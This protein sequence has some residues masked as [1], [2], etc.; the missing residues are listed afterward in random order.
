VCRS[1]GVLAV[2]RLLTIIEEELMLG[3]KRRCRIHSAVN[4]EMIRIELLFAV[5]RKDSA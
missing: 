4:D 2:L 3:C 5:F 1:C